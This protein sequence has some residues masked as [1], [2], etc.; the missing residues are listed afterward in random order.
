MS[1]LRRAFA[2]SSYRAVYS[3]V[4][5]AALFVWLV[6]RGIPWWV[7]L[8]AAILSTVALF[9]LAVGALY[10]YAKVHYPVRAEEAR[11]KVKRG[12]HTQGRTG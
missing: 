11:A 4:G 9:M 8:P 6:V 7:A 5:G 1:M 3:L 10:V 2:R 12:R